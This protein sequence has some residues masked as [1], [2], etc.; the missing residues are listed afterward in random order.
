[1]AFSKWAKQAGK[2]ATQHSDKI[3]SGIDKA[4]NTAKQKQPTK[5]SY[6]DKAAAYAKKTVE[7]QKR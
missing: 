4:A 6:I 2:L 7:S 1:V 5:S 3:T